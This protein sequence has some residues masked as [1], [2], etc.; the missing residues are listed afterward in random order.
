[1]KLS[2]FDYPNERL[3]EYKMRVCVQVFKFVYRKNV[4][5]F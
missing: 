5:I 4:Y 2:N 1:M 3:S